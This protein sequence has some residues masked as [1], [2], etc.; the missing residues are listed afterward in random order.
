MI[1]RLLKKLVSWWQ[2]GIRAGGLVFIL[3]MMITTSEFEIP[4]DFPGYQ[5]S[6]SKL[7]FRKEQVQTNFEQ[8]FISQISNTS[9]Q[10]HPRL[11]RQETGFNKKADVIDIKF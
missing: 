2:L 10:Q 11:R 3:L 4:L 8:Y 5:Y 7:K 6:K 9:Q 1:I